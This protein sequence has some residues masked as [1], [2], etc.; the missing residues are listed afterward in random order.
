MAKH[1]AVPEWYQKNFAR[2][3]D[4]KVFVWRRNERGWDL[5]AK[6]RYPAAAFFSMDAYRAK[7]DSGA[8]LV[9]AEPA[10]AEFDRE[11][12]PAIG[13]LVLKHDADALPGVKTDIPRTALQR[14]MMTLMARE[15]TII[16]EGLANGLDKRAV[17]TGGIGNVRI[18][19]P[20]L[21]GTELMVM[22][23]DGFEFIYGTA[24]FACL[25]D[26]HSGDR[27]R[28]IPLSRRV[29]AVWLLDR[30]PGAGPSTIDRIHP[31]IGRGFNSSIFRRSTAVAAGDE[32]EIARLMAAEKRRS[33]RGRAAGRRCGGGRGG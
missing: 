2:E 22:V 19:Q 12:A 29:A 32:T 31:R 5:T 23:A 10:H 8:V 7:D 11:L 21:D 24:V 13:R 15:Q 27:Y 16:D 14:L 9:D 25:D 20:A 17:L 6:W 33:R 18:P 26:V 3:S 1:Q 4:G 28:A 30:R